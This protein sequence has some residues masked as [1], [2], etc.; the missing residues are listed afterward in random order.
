MFGAVS[1]NRD[2]NSEYGGGGAKPPYLALRI[3]VARRW[4]HKARCALSRR[5]I[6]LLLCVRQTTYRLSFLAARM[7][8][9]CVSLL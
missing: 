1:I 7:Y 6:S 4:Q 5:C 3:A 8:A 9:R 2:G